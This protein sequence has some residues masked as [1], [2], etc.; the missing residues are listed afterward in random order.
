MLVDKSTPAVVV[1]FYAIPCGKGHR[2]RGLGK[3]LTFDSAYGLAQ[4]V[5]MTK[6]VELDGNIYLYLAVLIVA[7]LAWVGKTLVMPEGMQIMMITRNNFINMLLK[8]A[9][10]N[11]YNYGLVSREALELGAEGMP[12]EVELVHCKH[13]KSRLD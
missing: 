12:E 4:R 2:W 11:Y 1:F 8:E 7:T 13:L 3:K 9:S 5:P 10:C 6:L